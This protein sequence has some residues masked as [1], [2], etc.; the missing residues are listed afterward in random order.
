MIGRLRHTFEC[1]FQRRRVED[2]LDEE[3]QSSF[4]M[5]VDRYVASGLSPA[6][7]RRAA[8]IDFEGVEQVKERVRDGLPG[9]SVH[10]LS[11]DV[12]YAWRGLWRRPSF[13][14]VALVTWTGPG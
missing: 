1:L 8:R 11:Q 5:V 14:V 12:L 3:L 13:A 2:D 10:T 4:E 6:R 9:S 7:A